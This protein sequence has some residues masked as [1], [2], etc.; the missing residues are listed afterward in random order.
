[1][2]FGGDADVGML[3]NVTTLRIERGSATSGLVPTPEICCGT[4]SVAAGQSQTLA[5]TVFSP[6]FACEQAGLCLCNH[7]SLRSTDA[8]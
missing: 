4:I 6:D 3:Q 2:G 8:Q 5:N 1:M 7:T